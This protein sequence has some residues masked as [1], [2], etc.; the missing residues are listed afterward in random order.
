MF[1][2][3]E[4]PTPTLPPLATE[5]ALAVE[6]AKLARREA[7]LDEKAA[8]LEWNLSRRPESPEVAATKLSDQPTVGRW[9][10][11]LG[12]NKDDSE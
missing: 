12:L 3:S 6:R 7:E 11:R 2:A 8:A 5:V 4:A 9:L 1:S 10:S